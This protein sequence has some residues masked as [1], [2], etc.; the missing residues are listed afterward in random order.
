M[1]VTSAGANKILKKL[2]ERKEELESKERRDNTYISADNEEALIPDYSYTEV[3]SDINRINEQIMKIKHTLNVVNTSNYVKVGS[4]EYSIDEI[5]VRMAQL[6]RR[7]SFLQGLKENSEKTRLG[8][9]NLNNLVEYRYIN[10]CMAEVK[11]DYEKIDNEITAMQLGL[12]KF[13]QTFEFDI[14]DI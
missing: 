3:N 6:N 8:A 12:D 5:L 1:K 14:I 2:Q 9:R 10:Y 13:N 11:D 7:K 4:N